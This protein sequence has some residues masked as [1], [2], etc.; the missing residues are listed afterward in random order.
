MPTALRS[1][2]QVLGHGSI[3]DE[4]LQISC[5]PRLNGSGFGSLDVQIQVSPWYRSSF[6]F[7]HSRM[8]ACGPGYA[9]TA[10][11]SVIQSASASDSLSLCQSSIRSGSRVGSSCSYEDQSSQPAAYQREIASDNNGSSREGDCKLSEHSSDATFKHQASW[12]GRS[13]D[14]E[15]VDE[16]G[17]DKGF[18][19]CPPNHVDSTETAG[20]CQ[21]KSLIMPIT[22]FSGLAIEEAAHKA[23]AAQNLK[24]WRKTVARVAARSVVR[25]NTGQ[26]ERNLEL[27]LLDEVDALVASAQERQDC[28]DNQGLSH[29]AEE[30]AGR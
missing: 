12:L 17:G 7:V 21:K 13:S 20:A 29:L 22:S 23:A 6:R 3:V 30:G 19:P 4:L 11:A 10:S 1:L 9:R 25:D 24:S 5:T 16:H 27:T 18:S 14:R 2:H 8:L 15:R 28:K 26:W